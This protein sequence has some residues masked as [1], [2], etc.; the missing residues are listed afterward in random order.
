M[1]RLILLNVAVFLLPFALYA[2]WLRASRGSLGGRRWSIRTILGLSLAGT[3]LMTAMLV[4]LT[5]FESHAPGQYTPPP[6]QD[7]K[8]VPGHFQ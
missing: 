2:A 6:I 7:G 4:V 1:P 3:L 5:S 8:V